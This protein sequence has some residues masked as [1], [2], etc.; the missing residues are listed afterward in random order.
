ML[1]SLTRAFSE[2]FNIRSWNARGVMPK[3]NDIEVAEKKLTSAEFKNQKET[4]LKK[5]KKT[6]TL[7]VY[8]G[9]KRKQTIGNGIL[10]QQI[11]ESH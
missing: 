10:G 9:Q 3:L 4:Q 5:I 6:V 11:T 8:P 1:K 7:T 2:V